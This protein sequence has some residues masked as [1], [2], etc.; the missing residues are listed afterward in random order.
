[1]KGRRP[2]PVLDRFLAKTFKTETC[3][4]WT[5][6]IDK[7]GYARI[8]TGSMYDGTRTIAYAHRWAY[9]HFVGPIPT[10]LHIDHLCRVRHCVNPEHLEPVTC[11]ENLR[12]GYWGALKTHC[13]VGHPYSGNNLVLKRD[14][15]RRCRECHRLQENARYHRRRATMSS[16]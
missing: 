16:N 15:S 4:L 3:W 7:S 8:S 14:G 12:R 6:T 11:R 9:E 1:M 10:G 5:S 2:T 13:P